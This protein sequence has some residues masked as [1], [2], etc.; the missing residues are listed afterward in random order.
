MAACRAGERAGRQ[1]TTHA[2]SNSGWNAFGTRVENEKT[3]RWAEVRSTL[4]LPAG[5][6]MASHPSENGLVP[7]SETEVNGAPERIRTSDPQIRSLMQSIDIVI[8]F[9]QTR[10]K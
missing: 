2:R 3:P 8:D 9:M 4:D 6:P 7:M 1:A 10:S 5:L